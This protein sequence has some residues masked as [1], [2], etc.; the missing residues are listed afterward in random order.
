MTGAIRPWTDFERRERNVHHVYPRHG[1]EH[2]TE[3][4]ECWCSPEVE[5]VIIDGAEVGRVVIHREEN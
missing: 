1:R 2:E 4:G 3:G 5:P